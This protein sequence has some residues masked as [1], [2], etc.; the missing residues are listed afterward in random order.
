[1]ELNFVHTYNWWHTHYNFIFGEKYCMDPVYRTELDM[2]AQRILYD[3]YGDLGLGNKD[4]KPAPHLEIVGHRYI[5]AVLGCKIKYFDNQPPWA[6]PANLTDD[7]VEKLEVPDLENAYP[8]PEVMRLAEILE[9]KYGPF[10]AGQN[11][12]GLLNGA[13]PVRGDQMLLD[14][15][16]K[17]HL[18]HKMMDVVKNTMIAT[19]K[20]FRKKLKIPP[21]GGGVGNC[22]NVFISGE[23]YRAFN[24]KYDAE[25]VEYFSQL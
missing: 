19:D 16:E 25:L 24:L 9:K 2:E 13:I 21:A 14:F 15:Y 18:A 8:T 10:V 7:Q 11:L 1:M 4:P 12:G 22:N 3:R 20:L 23:M 17:P 5:P 6:E